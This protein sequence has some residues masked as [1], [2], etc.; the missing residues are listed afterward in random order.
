MKLL[1]AILVFMI[2]AQPVRAGFCDMQPSGDSAA[3]GSMQHGGMQHDMPGEGHPAHDCCAPAGEDGGENCDSMVQ[4]GACSVA[5][6]AVF[7]LPAIG[8]VPD[9]AFRSGL[10]DSDVPPSHA[11]PPYRPPIHIS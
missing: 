2:A 9:L 4:C 5:A 6:A 10:N 8:P 11:S 1:A 7:A 3:H